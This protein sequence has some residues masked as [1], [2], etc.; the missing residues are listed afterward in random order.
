MA[1][2]LSIVVIGY[3]ASAIYHTVKPLPQGLDFTGQLRH[4]NVKFLADQTYMDAQGN[5]FLRVS[6]QGGRDGELDTPALAFEG[7]MN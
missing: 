5:V 3:I 7:R 2:I 6:Q 1:V 4:A